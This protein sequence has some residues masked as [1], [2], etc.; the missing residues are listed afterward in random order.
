MAGKRKSKGAKAKA[1]FDE[2]ALTKLTSQIDTELSKP[3]SKDQK[4]KSER[5]AKNNTELPKS[6][7]KDQK[8]KPERPEKRKR[9][10]ND[11]KDAHP[12]KRQA[13]EAKNGS[14][15]P[16]KAAK[17]TKV[18]LLEEIK[19][20]GGDEADLELVTGIDSDA[21]EDQAPKP[22]ASSTDM[23]KA[24]KKE[25]ANF[26]AG[27]GFDEVR[28]DDGV[29]D[30]EIE[31]P[32]E[33]EWE[34]E[35]EDEG[36]EEEE[37][38]EEEKEAPPAEKSQGRS[39][40]GK[41]VFE[42][43][44]DWHAVSQDG[45]PAP[46]SDDIRNFSTTINSLKTYAKTLLDADAAAYES[47][48][49]KSSTRKFMSTIMTSGTM[50]D[51]VSALTLAIQESPVHNVKTLENLVNLAGKK[52][53]EQAIAALGALVDLLG[54]GVVLPSDRRLRL[55]SAQP[56]LLGTLQTTSITSWSPEKSLPGKITKAHLIMWAYEEWLKETYFKI[57]QLLE[58]WCGDEIEYSRSRSLD[59]V[60]GLLRDKPEQ[61][62][63]LLRLLVN[64]LGDR[65]KKIASRTSYLILQLLTTHPAMKGIVINAIEQEVLL[66][67]GQTIRPKYYAITTLNQTILT[68]KE[69]QIADTLVRIYFDLF[70]ALLKVGALNSAG[71][72]IE[73]NAKGGK[74]KHFK[75]KKDAKATADKSGVVPETETAEKMVSAILSGLNRALPFS[76]TDDETLEGHLDTLFKITHSSNFNTAI[77]ALM[78]VQQ[79][80]LTKHVAVDQF[81]RTLYESLLD[82]RLIRSSKQALY[83]NLLYRSLKNDVDVRRVKA[84]VKRMLQVCY[85][86][87]P[88]FVCGILFLVA[89]LEETFP[90]LKTLLN[91]P[92]EDGEEEEFYVDA[93]VK[94][95]GSDAPPRHPGHKSQKYDGRRS[96]PRFADADQSCLWEVI[97]YFR[98]FHPSVSV[99]A[100]NLLVK[101]KTIPKPELANHTL[102]NFL[103]KFVYKNPKA[104]DS[105]RG[106]SIMQPVLAAGSSAH[107]VVP[108]RGSAKNQE[109]VN[110][111][112]FWNKKQE[113][114]AAEDVFF[115]A[116]FSQVGK[117]SLEGK[118][119]KEKDAADGEDE[120]IDEDEIWG[121]L[122]NSRPDVEGEDEDVDMDMDDEDDMSDLGSLLDISDDDEDD[123]DDEDE[124][125]AED[126]EMEDGEDGSERGALF[127]DSEEEEEEKAGKDGKGK[128][129]KRELKKLPTFATADDYAALLAQDEDENYSD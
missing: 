108:G 102:I 1:A 31:G 83:L 22:K 73:N 35:Q 9:S 116:Y 99:F 15:K 43:R 6:S 123:E 80:T 111:A 59:F 75:G 23:D 74:K 30:E 18:D 8:Q 48:I 76:N 58:L 82:L 11:T 85:L 56:G 34:D 87:E 49:A 79:L 44:P 93:P 25:L 41:L 33:E 17:D 94:G 5:P 13:Q 16:K 10:D 20:L 37:E 129:R 60:F 125:E 21:E 64:K 121:A 122:V 106:A 117:P 19:L 62:A 89:Q 86:H 98:H 124:D 2:A 128:M 67:P 72:P 51:K 101:Q 71:A 109:N 53:R 96:D 114:V 26:A 104:A 78:L 24:L 45:L 110:S 38:E 105:K 63:N 115:H 127:S 95:D 107:V 88:P 14:A 28:D 52:S 91:E 126:V 84:F 57:I 50:S 4:Q 55:F 47:T 119:K 69:P 12:K 3:K 118:G 68:V 65:E 36:E 66:R 113:D 39:A 46:S 7:S 77:Q 27:L 103:D 42:P 81:Y 112:A 97:P 70:V 32:D 40:A 120:E 90:D 61:E 54:N 29:T 100:S 92:E